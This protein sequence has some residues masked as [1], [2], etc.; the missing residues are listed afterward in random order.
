MSSHSSDCVETRLIV[1]DS[2]SSVDLEQLMR[3]LSLAISERVLSSGDRGIFIPDLGRKIKSV[4]QLTS[5]QFAS[6]TDQQRF[7]ILSFM[8]NDPNPLEHNGRKQPMEEESSS[9]TPTTA[10]PS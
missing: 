5:Q 2:S 3:E 6:F 10:R 8:T 9:T 1:V 4:S 7:F